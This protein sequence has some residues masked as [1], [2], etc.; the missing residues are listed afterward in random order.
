VLDGGGGDDHLEG[1]GLHD[2]CWGRAGTNTFASCESVLG[3]RAPLASTRRSWRLCPP[4]CYQ[5]REGAP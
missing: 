2:V 1:N 3:S 4:Y 5:P